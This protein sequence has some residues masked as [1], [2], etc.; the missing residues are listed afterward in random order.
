MELSRTELGIIEKLGR[1][2]FRPNELAQALK[3]SRQQAYVA[4]NRLGKKGFV[5]QK[6]N[7]AGLS[8]KTHVSLLAK[9]LASNPNLN[10]ILSGS[11]INILSALI[12]PRTVAE[13]IK[14][15]GLGKSIVYKKIMQGVN[16]SII[17][18]K[19]KKYFLKEN[20]WPELKQALNEIKAYEDNIDPRVPVEARVYFK[21]DSRI[22]FSTASGQDASLTA[23]SMYKDNGLRVFFP[24]NYYFLPKKNLGL[25]EIFQHSLQIAEKDKEHR[26]LLYAALFYLKH[27]SLLGNVRNPALEKI[28][29]VLKGKKISGYPSLAEIKEK[30]MQYNIK[31]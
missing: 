8:Q 11:G 20:I 14:G 6:R 27:K 24:V 30:A 28:K 18:K 16:L 1:G 15:T 26:A 12:Q 22:L 17:G 5:S 7:S 13:L 25:K 9:L 31:I 4:L 29:K 21:D 2:I 23:F 19:N 3:K 10:E